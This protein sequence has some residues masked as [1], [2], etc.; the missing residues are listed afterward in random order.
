MT[1]DNREQ[2]R[3]YSQNKKYEYR[4]YYQAGDVKKSGESKDSRYD[5]DPN[6]R[7][8]PHRYGYEYQKSE[9][10]E[11]DAIPF[12]VIGLLVSIISFFVPFLGGLMGIFAFILSI[13]SYNLRPNGWAIAGIIIGILRLIILFFVLV[14]CFIALGFFSGL[15]KALF[16]GL[17]G[18]FYI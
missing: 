5:Y 6:Y 12:G 18:G 8:N 17:L 9:K 1:G 15:V 7:P 14:V 3:N 2:E 16:G 13:Y 4:D 11:T 10:D